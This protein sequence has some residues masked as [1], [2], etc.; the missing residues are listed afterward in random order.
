M[1]RKQSERRPIHEVSFLVSD[2]MHRI[3]NLLG[4]MRI[5]HTMT[6]EGVVHTGD[7]EAAWEELQTTYPDKLAHIEG[8]HL[9][10]VLAAETVG[11][12]PG[13]ITWVKQATPE[14]KRG[15]FE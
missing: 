11:L 10:G 8:A 3:H 12:N 4:K 1:S 6:E 14:A 13:R 2:D 9:V 5:G 7:V 15:R